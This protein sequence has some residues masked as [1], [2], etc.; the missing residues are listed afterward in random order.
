[1]NNIS[2]KAIRQADPA[3]IADIVRLYQA[4]GWWQEDYTADFIPPVLKKSF[5]VIAAFDGQRLVGMGRAISDGV[6]DAYIQDIAVLPEY[7]HQGIATRIVQKII[8]R[9]RHRGVDWIGLIGAPGTDQLYRRLGFE[10]MPGYQPMTIMHPHWLN[11]NKPTV[12]D[13]S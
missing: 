2:I 4:A 8:E 10:P 5:C 13:I 9:L 6:S 12:G 7:R 3:R 11:N 1:M